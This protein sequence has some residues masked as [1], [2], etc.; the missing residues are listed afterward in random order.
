MEHN[1]HAIYISLYHTIQICCAQARDIRM[2]T[3]LKFGVALGVPGELQICEIDW[4]W[5]IYDRY[6]L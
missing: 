6:S 3:Q 1:S 2:I 4:E 5:T